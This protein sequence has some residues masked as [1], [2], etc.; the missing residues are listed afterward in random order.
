MRLCIWWSFLSLILENLPE[1]TG[2]A[3]GLRVLQSV[4]IPSHP[5]PSPCL[6][7][8]H[9]SEVRNLI[10]QTLDDKNRQMKKQREFPARS[11]KNRPKGGMRIISLRAEEG[12]GP[13]PPVPSRWHPINP[14]TEL[15]CLALV[16]LVQK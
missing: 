16:S 13:S 10:W 6:P 7:P 1:G 11:Y 14:T 2:F 9:K 4:S 12:A 5:H 15:L 3:S 8:L